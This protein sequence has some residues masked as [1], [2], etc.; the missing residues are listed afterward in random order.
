MPYRSVEVRVKREFVPAEAHAIAARLRATAARARLTADKL[1][2]ALGI[3]EADWE[4]RAKTR[5]VDTAEHDPAN[6][7]AAASQA[8]GAAHGIENLTVTVWESGVRTVWVD[9]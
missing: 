1:R 6:L 2:R 4:G 9:D 7:E 5:F 3:L 8:E